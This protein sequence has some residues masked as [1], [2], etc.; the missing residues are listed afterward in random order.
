[1]PYMTAGSAAGGQ[2]NDGEC[3]VAKMRLHLPKLQ[4]LMMAEMSGI[5]S[6]HSHVEADVDVG[7]DF[8]ETQPERR[9]LTQKR[10]KGNEFP[11]A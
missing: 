10:T 11:L 8:N 2:E 5:S 4:I 1:M 7:V 9:T 6:T 3:G